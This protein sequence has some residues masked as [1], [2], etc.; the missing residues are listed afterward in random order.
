MTVT[1]TSSLPVADRKPNAAYV[2]A[3]A[4]AAAAVAPT[5]AA[6]ATTTTTRKTCKRRRIESTDGYADNTVI[7]DQMTD[8]RNEQINSTGTCKL[9]YERLPQ[10]IGDRPTVQANVAEMAAQSVLP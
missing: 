8:L 5:A 3:D 1:R 10:P 7:R 6:T 2:S 4:A 9:I